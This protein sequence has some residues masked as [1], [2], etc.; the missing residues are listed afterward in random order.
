MQNRERKMAKLEGMTCWSPDVFVR[1]ANEHGKT[2]DGDL[3][4]EAGV[5][6]EQIRKIYEAEMIPEYVAEGIAPLIGLTP[7]TL[8]TCVNAYAVATQLATGE[9]ALREAFDDCRVIGD[10][11]GRSSATGELPASEAKLVNDTLVL[12]ED[13][14]ESNL[15]FRREN[16][17]FWPMVT[18]SWIFAA[19]L[20]RSE[21]TR[22]AAS[23]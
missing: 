17:R 8:L 11:F 12:M 22:V 6:P 19:N 16:A 3:A 13:V 23:G 10:G 14:I 4:R 21:A 5:S 2:D 9:M 7:V 15:R 1:L 18:S 20:T